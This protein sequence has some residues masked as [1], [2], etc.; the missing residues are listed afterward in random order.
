[1]T[2]ISINVY[3]Q[4]LTFE[5]NINRCTNIIKSNLIICNLYLIR[6]ITTQLMYL[7]SDCSPEL[8]VLSTRLTPT[9]IHWTRIIIKDVFTMPY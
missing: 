3:V 7:S 2:L 5:Q 6:L 1:M 8:K 9:V 4:Q